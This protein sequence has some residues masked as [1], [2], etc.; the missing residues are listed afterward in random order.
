VSI[1]PF[2]PEEADRRLWDW[3]APHRWGLAYRALGDLPENLVDVAPSTEPDGRDACIV[4]TRGENPWLRG[5]ETYR[6]VRTKIPLGPDESW[7]LELDSDDYRLAGASHLYLMAIPGAQ[8]PEPQKN[9][10]MDRLRR[11]FGRRDM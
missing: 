5:R 9:G 6:D 7:V 8:P 11:R 1:P 10:P 3:D 2:G 4:G